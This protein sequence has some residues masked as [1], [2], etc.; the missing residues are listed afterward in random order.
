MQVVLGRPLG[1]IPA[2]F[3][4]KRGQPSDYYGRGVVAGW[5]FGLRND[6]R[7]AD[8]ASLGNHR[9]ALESAEIRFIDTATLVSLFC[10]CGK[11]FEKFRGFFSEY[12]REFI[13]EDSA[14]R[15]L[16]G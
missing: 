1:T 15:G 14:Y 16:H 10:Q 11:Y 2:A 13:C 6:G 3:F 4:F 12:L 5:V 9:F 8:L 7:G